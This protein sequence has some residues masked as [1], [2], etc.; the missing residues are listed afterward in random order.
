MAQG[1]RLICASDTLVDGGDGVRFDV[2]VQ[3][4]IVPAFA[5]RF[6]GVVRAYLNRCAHVAVELDWMPGRF[7]DPER[8][9]LL[10]STHG[11]EYDPA[12]GRCL[13]GPCRGGLTP[14]SVEE[15]D[16]K[17]FLKEPMDG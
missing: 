17:V 9:V 7:L 8:N 16:G 15:C 11:A 10:C 1:E 6:R 2:R 14:V 5:V 12:T 3:G 13:G 4:S